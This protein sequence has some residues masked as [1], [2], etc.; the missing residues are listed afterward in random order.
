MTAGLPI[1]ELLDRWRS[2][3]ECAAHAIYKRYEQRLINL[4]GEECDRNLRSRVDPD[5][6]MLSVLRTALRRMAEGQYTIDPSGTLWHLLRQIANR[7]ILKQKEHHF[8][9]KRDVRREE[10]AAPEDHAILQSPAPCEL[11]AFADELDYIQQ[12]LERLDFDMFRLRLDGL[13]YREIASALD[14][15]HQT[16]RYR[17]MRVQRWLSDRNG[18]PDN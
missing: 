16:V 2:G 7:K 12:Q 8:A 15:P 18:G 13:S 10:R 9:Q 4:V 3:D 1:R 5:D 11:A 14:R 17:L 6:I